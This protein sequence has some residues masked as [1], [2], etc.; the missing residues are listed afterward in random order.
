MPFSQFF[1]SSFSI[2]FI[3]QVQD[4]TNARLVFLISVLVE[5]EEMVIHVIGDEVLDRELRFLVSVC[6][7]KI[8][9]RIKRN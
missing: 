5:S 2:L 8:F 3:L 9:Y 4:A 6:V 1:K 7:A